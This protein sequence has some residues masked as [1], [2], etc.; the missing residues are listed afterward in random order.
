MQ[1]K[2]TRESF[3]HTGGTKDYHLALLEAI[4]ADEAILMMRF[5]KAGQHGQI[6]FERGN[7]FNMGVEY[8]NKHREKHDNRGYVH[9]LDRIGDIGSGIKE[10]LPIYTSSINF[11]RVKDFFTREELKALKEFDATKTAPFILLTE[12]DVFAALPD[13]SALEDTPNTQKSKINPM[14]D[15]SWGLF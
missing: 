3:R 5:G 8:S 11:D 13:L 9:E 4:G 15:P 2:L 6:K 10:R 14:D 7:K 12:Q 1:F